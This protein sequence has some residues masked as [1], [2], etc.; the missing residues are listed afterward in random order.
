[1][2]GTDQLVPLSTDLGYASSNMLSGVRARDRTALRF[3]VPRDQ[4][5]GIRAITAGGFSSVAIDE[6]KQ[7]LG[8]RVESGLRSRVGGSRENS[9]QGLG[10]RA[11]RLGSE[12]RESRIEGLTGTGMSIT[13]NDARYRVDNVRKAQVYTWGDSADGQLGH[14]DNISLNGPQIMKVPLSEDKEKPDFRGT[15]RSV[16]ARISLCRVL[17]ADSAICIGVRYDKFGTGIGRR[18]L[19]AYACSPGA[20]SSGR[21]LA[22]CYPLLSSR[23]CYAMSGTDAGYA[24]T[25]PGRAQLHAC[26]G[27]GGRVRYLPTRLLRDARVWC[28]EISGTDVAYHPTLPGGAGE[29]F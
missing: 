16:A 5:R 20:D 29:G 19:L 9:F 28:Y 22:T 3:A 8:S 21:T 2:S 23:L 1:M 4:A 10:S 17:R 13:C 15:F 26:D 12:G 11:S 7:G 27:F 24:A 18:V 25:L 6:A 14:G